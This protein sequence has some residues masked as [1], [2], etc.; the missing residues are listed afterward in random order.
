M[1]NGISLPV[2]NLSAATEPGLVEPQK[3]VLK[4]SCN[5]VEI[6]RPAYTHLLMKFCRVLPPTKS[7]V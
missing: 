1:N 5:A 4:V 6:I 2:I 7:G 3:V